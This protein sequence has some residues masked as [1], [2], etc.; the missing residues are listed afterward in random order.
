MRNEW[1][2][3][4]GL[5]ITINHM[6]SL[7]SSPSLTKENYDNWAIRMKALLGSQGVWES[8]CKGYEEP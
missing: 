7:P 6:S 4:V 3:V 1:V 2:E 8:I 5:G